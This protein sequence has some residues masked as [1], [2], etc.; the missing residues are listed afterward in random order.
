MNSRLHI[1]IEGCRNNFMS[2]IFLTIRYVK[3][4]NTCQSQKLI[5]KK[6]TSQEKLFEIKLQIDKN[7]EIICN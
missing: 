6:K 4:R 7:P 5:E 3:L 2:K 1:L